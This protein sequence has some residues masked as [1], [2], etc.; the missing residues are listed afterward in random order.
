MLH[1]APTL[2][3]AWTRRHRSACA[4]SGAF[5]EPQPPDKAATVE[6]P[7]LPAPSY[8]SANLILLYSHITILLHHYIHY[9]FSTLIYRK[10]R[11]PEK[12]ESQKVKENSEKSKK[13][14]KN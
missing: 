11:I 6:L 4:L 14:A 1:Y 7:R 3:S 5:A 13:T 2:S 8:L 12:A 10:N 9:V